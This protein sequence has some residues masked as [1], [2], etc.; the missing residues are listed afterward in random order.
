MSMKNILVLLIS[1]ILLFASCAKENADIDFSI[2][3]CE[4]TAIIDNTLFTDGPNS[5]VDIFD[6]TL[7]GDCLLI[8]FAA[9]GCDGNS[10]VVNLYD[11]GQ[12]IYTNPAQRNLR[13]SLD[14]NED[15]EAYIVK[16]ISFDISS[17]KDIDNEIYLNVEGWD[18]NILY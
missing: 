11:S 8:K 2:S 15:C 3:V 18:N 13:F 17:L 4:S 6:V 9:G 10:W 5:D 12:V 14:N 7:N 1:S 16:S